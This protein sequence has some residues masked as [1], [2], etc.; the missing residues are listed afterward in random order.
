MSLANVSVSHRKT[1]HPRHICK[2][3]KITTNAYIKKFLVNK[4]GSMKVTKTFR[5]ITLF[6]NKIVNTQ[7]FNKKYNA[8]KEFFYF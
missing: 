2:C 4:N 8:F 6:F 3:E 7:I 5:L 1:L